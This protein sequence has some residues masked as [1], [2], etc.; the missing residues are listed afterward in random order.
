L[1]PTIFFRQKDEIVYR[2]LGAAAKVFSR[3]GFG[4][5]ESAMAL[6]SSSR[7]DGETRRKLNP[8]RSKV[9]YVR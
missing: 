6:F 5:T 3:P 7:G 9:I 4:L 1:I 2:V 8:L